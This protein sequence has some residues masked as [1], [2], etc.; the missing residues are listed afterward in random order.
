MYELLIRNATLIDPA[1]QV[2]ARKDVAFADGRVVAVADSLAPDE[3]R[4]VI[5]GAGQLLTPGWIDLHVHVF[6]G[7]SY[8]GIP[9]DPNCIARGVTTAVDAGTAG[10]DTF[11]GF[12]KYVIEAS[13]TRLFA[14]LN[15]SS[16][17]MIAQEVGELEDIRWADVGKALKLIEANRDVIL[18]VKVRLQRGLCCSEASGLRPLYLAREAADAAGLP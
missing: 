17:G 16:Q 7:V 8:L 1:Q 18:G 11:P 12:R 2:H 10:A 4:E 15:I 9:A 13:A 6:E 3:A 14:Q 5:D